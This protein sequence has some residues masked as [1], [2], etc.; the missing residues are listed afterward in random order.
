MS[1]LR[2]MILLIAGIVGLVCC[3][4]VDNSDQGKNPIDMEPVSYKIQIAVLEST[5]NDSM[6]NIWEEQ[7]N[8]KIELEV[9]ENS[10]AKC[11]IGDFSDLDEAQNYLIELK[12]K[13]IK[14]AFIV[15]YHKGKRIRPIESIPSDDFRT[16]N[17]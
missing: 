9:R 3:Q 14:D 1:I 13:G 11:M 7:L 8:Q 15:A 17:P 5:S 12:N 2:Q 6:I 4:S 16:V 10:D